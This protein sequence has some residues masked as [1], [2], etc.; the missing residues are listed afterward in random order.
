MCCVKI[1]WVQLCLM[2]YNL[3]IYCVIKFCCMKQYW[4]FKKV[5]LFA[6]AN[7]AQINS[8]INSRIY[9]LI[10]KTCTCIFAPIA[11]WFFVPLTTLNYC[12]QVRGIGL[13]RNPQPGSRPGTHVFNPKSPKLSHHPHPHNCPQPP[14]H[15]RSLMNHHELQPNY[16][17]S[18]RL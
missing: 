16:L 15:F 17:R 11:S 7:Y 13:H 2:Q 10:S 8:R 5:S 18:C 14:P 6:S 12:C 9:Q 1:Y 3:M 4:D